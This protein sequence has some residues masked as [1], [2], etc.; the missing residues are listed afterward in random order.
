MGDLEGEHLTFEAW[1]P[2][3]WHRMVQAIHVLCGDRHAAEDIV[4]EALFKA[5]DRWASL[6]Q[7]SAWTYTTAV[8]L[9]RRRWRITRREVVV[10]SPPEGSVVATDS[11][12]DLWDAVSR[13]PRAQRITVTLRYVA[14]LSQ[15]EIAQVMGVAEGTVAASLHRGRRRLR[16]ALDAPYATAHGR[17]QKEM[18][19]VKDHG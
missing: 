7:P 12:P 1:Y 5:H 6:D 8:N 18:T 19:E 11:D 9:A 14:D 13:L 3:V 4:S 15:S 16:A 17:D 10:A 2:G